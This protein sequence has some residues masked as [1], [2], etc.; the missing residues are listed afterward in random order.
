MPCI[1]VYYYLP[2]QDYKT[3]NSGGAGNE[4]KKGRR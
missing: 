3:F 1:E 2:L 4:I